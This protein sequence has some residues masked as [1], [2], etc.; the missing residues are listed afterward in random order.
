MKKKSLHVLDALAASRVIAKLKKPINEGGKCKRVV[1]GKGILT[2]LPVP[3]D[4]CHMH[5]REVL[6][7]KVNRKSIIAVL[8]IG[9]KVAGSKKQPK[10]NDLYECQNMI[11]FIPYT[12]QKAGCVVILRSEK[13]KAS[14]SNEPTVRVTT[15]KLTEVAEAKIA[16]DLHDKEQN[17]LYIHFVGGRLSNESFIGQG[18]MEAVAESLKEAFEKILSLNGIVEYAAGNFVSLIFEKL[19][20][21]SSRPQ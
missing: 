1:L 9:Q 13:D 18:S 19:S 14:K 11:G 5:F 20:V 6:I 16:G 8:G 15:P 7:L 4:G 12:N 2:A 3:I 10:L 21:L 17:C